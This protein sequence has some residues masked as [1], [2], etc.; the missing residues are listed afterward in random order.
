MDKLKYTL[1]DKWQDL[2]LMNEDSLEKFTGFA[3]QLNVGD[4]LFLNNIILFYDKQYKSELKEEWY[5]Q[6]DT[7]PAIKPQIVSNHIT[8]KD[9]IFIQDK[10]NKLYLFST[11]GEKLWEYQITEKILGKVSQ[12]DYY[13]NKK[14]QILFNT[15]N[16]IYIIDRLGRLIEGFPK[17]LPKIASN[18]HALFDYNNKKDYRIIIATNDGDVI[19]LE[20]VKGWDFTNNQSII[21]EEL[22][23]FIVGN[24]DYILY[25]SVNNIALLARNGKIRVNY[26]TDANFTTQRLQID[27]KGTV[28]GITS[29][30]MLWRGNID[31][32]TTEIPLND[33][34]NNSKFIISQERSVR[35]EFNFP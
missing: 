1:N 2:L 28:Y 6:L 3:Y 12:I 21:L 30:G 20:K 26:N 16:K 13:K 8:N 9:Q 15:K 24:K 25:P 32:N 22:E 35:L 7:N 11:S 33:L 29:E 34:D 5:V 23:H 17:K 10:K 19:N 4:P 27:K 14:L 18:G 31:G